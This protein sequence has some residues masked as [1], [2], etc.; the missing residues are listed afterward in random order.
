MSGKVLWLTGCMVG[1]AL[2]PAGAVA[3]EIEPSVGFPTAVH[4]TSIVT[5]G[6]VRIAAI[7]AGVCVVWLGHNTLVRGIMGEFEFEGQFGKLKGSAPG[8]L[9]VLLGTLAIGWAL[10][11][12]ASGQLRVVSSQTEQ[13]D[14]S[15]S[16]GPARTGAS[17][18]KPAFM[19]D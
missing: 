8:L 7:G 17:D 16:D 14:E 5:N 6:L 4:I 18:E 1:I 9:F 2:W 15:A 10:Q 13:V 19:N 11:T 12:T 3:A